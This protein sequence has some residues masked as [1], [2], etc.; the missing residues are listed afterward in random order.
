M[1]TL[2]V[3][4]LQHIE[5]NVLNY[6]YQKLLLASSKILNTSA[7][8]FNLTFTKGVCSNYNTSC[9]WLGHQMV[10][11]NLL[12]LLNNHIATN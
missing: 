10:K 9:S 7:G 4:P 3:Y 6:A 12:E 2:S 1:S 11:L 5:S 8:S